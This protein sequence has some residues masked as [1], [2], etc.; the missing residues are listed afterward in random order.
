MYI[1]IITLEGKHIADI[2]TNEVSLVRTIEEIKK[3]Y[4]KEKYHATLITY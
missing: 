2:P 3:N 1:K 4:P